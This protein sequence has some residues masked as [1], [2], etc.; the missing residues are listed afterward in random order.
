MELERVGAVSM[1]GMRIQVGGKVDDIDGIHRTLLHTDTTPNTQLFRQVC[2]LGSGHD[3][4][5]HFAHAHNRARLFTLLV[6]SFWFASIRIN[7]GDPCQFAG[8][9]LLSVGLP[10]FLESRFGGHCP[11]L[12]RETRGNVIVQLDMYAISE[13]SLASTIIMYPSSKCTCF[14]F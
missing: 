11:G 4:H 6:T 14:L 13:F 7:N 10:A 8:H 12:E 9:S 2:N 1:S 5:A 3:F